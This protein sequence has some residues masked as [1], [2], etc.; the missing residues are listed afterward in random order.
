[1][2]LHAYCN[3]YSFSHKKSRC[4][5]HRLQIKF[6]LFKEIIHLST[7]TIENSSLKKLITIPV[8]QH[9]RKV[10]FFQIIRMNKEITY[11]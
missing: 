11:A 9:F 5:Q 3:A 8:I 10:T 2:K 1:M 4:I 7:V 6:E